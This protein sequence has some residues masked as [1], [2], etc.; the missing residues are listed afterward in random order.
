MPRGKLTGTM[1]VNISRLKGETTHEVILQ[2]RWKRNNDLKKNLM[3]LEFCVKKVD[4][5]VI[6]APT[7]IDKESFELL[8]EKLCE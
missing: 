7:L 3:L 4:A 6:Y 8:A 1:D 5:L 2:V